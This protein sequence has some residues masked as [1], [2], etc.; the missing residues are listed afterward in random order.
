MKVLTIREWIHQEYDGIAFTCDEFLAI[1]FTDTAGKSFG[2][3]L[4]KS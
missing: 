1:S 3:Y 4:V 2:Q